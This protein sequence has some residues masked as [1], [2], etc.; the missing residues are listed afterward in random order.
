MSKITIAEWYSRVNATWGLHGR[1]IPHPT[2]EQAMRGARKLYRFAL[3]KTFTGRVVLTSG[4]RYTWVKRDPEFT[5]LMMMVNPNRWHG[6]DGIVH[7]LSHY[8]HRQL[9][10]GVR[11]HGAKHARIEIAMIKEVIK[12][13][14][15][16]DPPPR[17]TADQLLALCPV[18]LMDAACELDITYRRVQGHALTLIRQ[19]KARWFR[20]R[21]INLEET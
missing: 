4:N 5:G 6:E 2:P 8:A 7:L 12:R 17:S 13:G 9:N 15:L 14:W 20:R 3:G 11:P 1:F 18:T 21:L 19:G 10:P 16:G